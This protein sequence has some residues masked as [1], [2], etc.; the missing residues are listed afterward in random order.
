[1]KGKTLIPPARN[2]STLAGPHVMEVV[3]K[4]AQI[5]YPHSTMHSFC[6]DIVETYSHYVF[7]P[8]V[9]P[10]PQVYPRRFDFQ[11][12]K[13]RD[14]IGGPFGLCLYQALQHNSQCRS[15]SGKGHRCNPPPLLKSASSHAGS[16]PLLS[17]LTADRMFSEEKGS[18]LVGVL[19]SLSAPQDPPPFTSN[20]APHEAHV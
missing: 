6:H 17:V 7:P 5:T 13:S 8:W 14:P 19:C 11:D 15:A 3:A 16:L 12:F 20:A 1:M 9:S 4:G 2:A 10:Y 18:K